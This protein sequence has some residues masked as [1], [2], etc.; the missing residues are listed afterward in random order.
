[1][2]C[3]PGYD[4]W[5]RARMASARAVASAA[6]SRIPRSVH[7]EI[8]PEATLPMLIPTIVPAVPRKLPRTAASTVPTVAATMTGRCARKVSGLCARKA[9]TFSVSLLSVSLVMISKGKVMATAA[10][11]GG[12]VP[13]AIG[14]RTAGARAGRSPVTSITRRRL[15]TAS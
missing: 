13:K 14:Y 1:M 9:S 4:W 11:P 10:M 15:A 8:V 7:Q 2:A 6:D 3:A 12:T 5:P